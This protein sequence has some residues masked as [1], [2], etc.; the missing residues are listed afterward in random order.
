MVRPGSTIRKCG[1][2]TGRLTC[3]FCRHSKKAWRERFWKRWPRACLCLVAYETGVT[4][5]V[6]DGAGRA[7]VI[8]SAD[9][10]ALAQTP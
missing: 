3:L 6:V 8:P 7:W 1:R 9:T 5:I 2:F 4:D 10:D